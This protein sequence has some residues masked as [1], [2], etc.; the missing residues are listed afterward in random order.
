VTDTHTENSACPTC[1]AFRSAG[2][3]SVADLET[4]HGL[5][6][7]VLLEEMERQH[8]ETGRRSTRLASAVIAFLKLNGITSPAPSQRAVDALIAQMPD[9]DSLEALEVDRE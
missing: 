9:M 4:L 1:G 5:I 2:R 3:A 8:A 7:E 6:A